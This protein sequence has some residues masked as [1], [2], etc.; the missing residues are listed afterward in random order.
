M[1]L[2]L[3]LKDEPKIPSDERNT[4]GGSPFQSPE[5]TDLYDKTEEETYLDG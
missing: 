5:E 4:F 3:Y 2:E 1:E